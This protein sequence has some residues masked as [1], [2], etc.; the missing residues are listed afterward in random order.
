MQK[1]LIMHTNSPD[2]RAE[3]DGWTMED[4]DKVVWR[5]PMYPDA[6]IGLTPGVYGKYDPKTPLHALGCGWKL[7]APPS[8]M[9]NDD[10]S[11]YKGKYIN[12]KE[13]EVWA[14]WFVRDEW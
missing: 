5:T 6:P 10:G 4:G 12:D 3:V 11:I 14:W 7:L 9:L 8:P 1:V 13:Y 2:L